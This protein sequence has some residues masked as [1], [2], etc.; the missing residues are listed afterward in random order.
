MFLEFYFSS[1]EFCEIVWWLFGSFK[2]KYTRSQKCVIDWFVV[3]WLYCVTNMRQTSSPCDKLS[4]CIFLKNSTVL[5][6]F[7]AIVPDPI[8]MPDWI[9][10]CTRE[11]YKVHTWFPITTVLIILKECKIKS[12]VTSL[13]LRMNLMC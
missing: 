6:T 1:C 13:L 10:G 9:F 4:L 7:F 12:W 2:L 11:E 8:L 3:V 5:I